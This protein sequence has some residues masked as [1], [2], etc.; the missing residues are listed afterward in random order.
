MS[1]NVEAPEK[2]YWLPASP[3]GAVSKA[4]PFPGFEKPN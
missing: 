4:I 3:S 2:T 1:L